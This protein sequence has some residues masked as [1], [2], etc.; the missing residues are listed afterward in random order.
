MSRYMRSTRKKNCM[1][2]LKFMNQKYVRVACNVRTWWHL[3]IIWNREVHVCVV[4]GVHTH[5]H[6]Y[7]RINTHTWICNCVYTIASTHTWVHI[8]VCVLAIVYTQSSTWICDCVHTILYPRAHI[9]CVFMQH[10]PFMCIHAARTFHVYSCS[11]HLSCVFM[12]HAHFMCIHA[13]CTF[14]VYL[15]NTHLLTCSCATSHQST[16]T[17]DVCL[18]RDTHHLCCLMCV[19]WET[20]ISLIERNLPPGGV[21]IY[22]VPWSRAV[23]KWFHD[24]IQRS[25][26]TAT[27]CNTLQHTA[28]H[29]NMTLDTTR[30]K[31]SHFVV[32]SLTHSSWP[33]NIVNRKPP[34]GG[35]FLSINLCCVMC[36]LWETHIICV[37]DTHQTHK[38]HIRLSIWGGYDE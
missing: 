26:H 36:V 15:C 13:A 28:T 6:L 7:V 12:Q 37:R 38:T 5:L 31:R 27:H 18:M 3:R 20:H 2:V 14:H 22:Y 1:C 25:Q 35:G 8:H 9:S 24:E 33:G 17:S 10:A 11:T 21:S 23:S 30:Y 32:K 4:C 29:C 16:S 19:L 34:R